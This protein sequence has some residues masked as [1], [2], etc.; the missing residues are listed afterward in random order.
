MNQPGPQGQQPQNNAQA[1]QMAASQRMAQMPLYKP[2]QMRNIGLLTDEEKTKYERGLAQI[3]RLHDTHPAG[4][5]ENTDAKKKIVDFSKMLTSKIQARR[6]QLQQQQQQ[7]QQRQPGQQGQANPGAQAAAAAAAQKTSQSPGAAVG[8]TPNTGGNGPTAAQAQ[9]QPTTTAAAAPPAQ[10][11]NPAAGAAQAAA[12][13][14]QLKLPEHLANHVN[15][16]DFHA[17]PVP[18]Q[19]PD[20][21]KWVLDVKSR[22]ARALLTMETMRSN[23]QKMDA[24]I[25]DRN[26]KGNPLSAEEQ[27]SVMEK[28]AHLQ[29]A[30][31]DSMKFV[32]NI[33]KQLAV[34]QQK[35]QQQQQQQQANGSQNNQAGG[36]GA[37]QNNPMQGSAAT[38]NAAIEAAKNQQLAAAGR[39]PGQ[40]QQQQ[41]QGQQGQQQPTQVPASNS[42]AQSSP[43]TQAPPNS[44][45]QQQLPAAQNQQQ[46]ASHQQQQQ[47][48]VIKTEPGTQP[49]ST[50]IPAPLN[51]ALAS[52]AAAAGIPSA[53]TPTQNS[54]RVQ[55]PQSAT[56]TNGAPRALSHTAALSLANQRTNSM[57]SQGQQGS[58]PTPGGAGAGG[59]P[60]AGPAILGGAPGAGGQPGHPPAHPPQPTGQTL[61]SK[62]PI[63]KVLPEKA[64]QVPTPVS[65]SGA[66]YGRPTYSGG[67]GV[68]GGVMGQPALAKTPA[69]Q[70]EGEG[71]RVLNKKKLDEL[72]R[73]VCGGT[74]E[75]QEGNLLTPEVEEV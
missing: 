40:Q 25:K 55:T 26:E 38:V 22:Y 43:L 6:Q 15:Q 13:G 70:L 66:G 4:S 47:R 57:S 5:P 44:T 24:Q 73:Q 18:Q 30:Y 36:A 51:T 2:E 19:I 69:Y 34:A 21:A 35:Q 74:A 72:V 31:N 59:P 3:W 39:L 14:Q 11:A 53:G 12:P 62:M 16:L 27:K 49:A 54:A 64:T 32:E 45:A 60:T 29:K 10:A 8:G 42:Q 7:M 50:P 67:S 28:K 75:G 20:K 52:S 61:Q 37:A 46:Q 63:P 1:A 17:I 9:A 71:E 58:G 48:P 56:P 23:L 41:V 65:M 33:R 68:G